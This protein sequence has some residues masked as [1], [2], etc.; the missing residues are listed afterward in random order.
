MLLYSVMQSEGNS[1]C[2]DGV[3]DSFN[4]GSRDENNS[5]D[6]KQEQQKCS[7]FYYDDFNSL[8]RIELMHTIT[9]V[10]VAIK[11][12]VMS[13]LLLCAVFLLKCI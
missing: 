12:N 4:K 10:L 5:L 1:F 13:S 11:P 8:E 2:W 6:K 9:T 7:D 3:L